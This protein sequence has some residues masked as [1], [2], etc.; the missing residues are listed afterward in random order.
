MMFNDALATLNVAPVAMVSVLLIVTAANIPEDKVNVPFIAT[1]PVTD[2]LVLEALHVTPEAIVSVLAI[3]KVSSDAP[4]VKLV[5]PLIVTAPVAEVADMLVLETLKVEPAETVSAFA[6]ADITTGFNDVPDML[7]VPLVVTVPAKVKVAATTRVAVKEMPDPLLN[8][9]VPLNK[10]VPCVLL[11]VT[12]P[13]NVEAP[14]TLQLVLSIV[15]PFAT[16]YPLSFIVLLLPPGLIDPVEL[17]VS[18]PAPTLPI[19]RV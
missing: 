9:L 10:A 3:L 19:V 11:K 7:T 15:P 6:G 13:L 14:E 5:V 1:A 12:T 4:P 8:T 2:K 16:K 18:P 17:S